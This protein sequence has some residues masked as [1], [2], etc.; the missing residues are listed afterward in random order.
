MLVRA[1]LYGLREKN[2]SLAY[3]KKERP[4]LLGVVPRI[5]WDRGPERTPFSTAE[6][7][8]YFWRR[9]SALDSSTSLHHI[10]WVF[11]T[12]STTDNILFHTNMVHRSSEDGKSL[13]KRPILIS[14][15]STVRPTSYSSPL[16]AT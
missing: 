7:E 9:G 13:V 10:R 5:I 12:I 1:I 2:I 11:L 15:V 14:L 16:L 4:G 3:S 8:I 6:M